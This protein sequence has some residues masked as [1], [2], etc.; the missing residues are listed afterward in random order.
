LADVNRF[1]RFLKIF[2]GRAEG[3]RDGKVEGKI[4][5]AE[6]LLLAGLA[7]ADIVRATG[8]PAAEI[9]QLIPGA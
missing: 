7:P 2:H 5:V 4:E 9:E 3:F 1:S 6:N 8:L